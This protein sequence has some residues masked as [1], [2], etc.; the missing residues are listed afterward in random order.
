MTTEAEEEMKRKNTESTIRT[1][2]RD[3]IQN[4]LA[5]GMTMRTKSGFITLFRCQRCGTIKAELIDE[6]IMKDEIRM[7]CPCCDEIQLFEHA[8]VE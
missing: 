8:W 3:E 2:V 5:G 1:V 4:A 6:R 7:K